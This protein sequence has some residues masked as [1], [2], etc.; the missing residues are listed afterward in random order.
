[1][2][3]SL[4]NQQ[5]E[6]IKSIE[7]PDKIFDQKLNNELIYQV[8]TSSLS[9]ARQPLAFVKNRGEVRGGGKKPWAQK[10][11]GRARHGSIRSPIW[12]GGGFTFGPRQKE[13]NFKK[14]INKRQRQLAIS[15][16]LSQKLRDGELFVVDTISLEAPKTKEIAKIIKNLLPKLTNLDTKVSSKSKQ[17]PL[18]L[19][20]VSPKEA[21]LKRSARNLSKIKVS[22]LDNLNILDLLNFRYVIFLSDTLPILETLL[23]VK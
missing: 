16:V 23:I 17:F 22:T 8:Y 13:V 7:I 9:N 20:I 5:G 19:L 11:T 15:Q 18:C 12:K 21:L 2:E 14:K 1:M 6:T 10:G 4:Y 3:I